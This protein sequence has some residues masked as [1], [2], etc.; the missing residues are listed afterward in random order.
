MCNLK[1]DNERQI[2]EVEKES[3]GRKQQKTTLAVT[4]KQQKKI[5]H[6]LMYFQKQNKNI[7]NGLPAKKEE[8]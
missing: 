7:L 8:I 1:T 4:E 6:Y 2:W 3:G 5:P